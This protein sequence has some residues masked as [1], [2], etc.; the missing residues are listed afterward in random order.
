MQKYTIEEGW[1]RIQDD[2]FDLK[3][4]LS[5]LFEGFNQDERS[6]IAAS[7]CWGDILQEAIKRLCG[8]SDMWDSTDPTLTL[9]VLSKMEDRLISKCRW[10]LLRNLE[11]LSKNIASHQ[12]IYWKM[13]HD[14]NH[15]DFFQD[16]LRK[17]NIES[18]YTCDIKS[19]EEFMKMVE[20]KLD[21][22]KSHEEVKISLE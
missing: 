13:Y 7:L 14:P 15:G 4:N 12:H 8:E 20:E 19:H 10:S 1:L 3:L 6:Q 2:Q 22:M 9:E 21:A 11:D 5:Q 16:W 18:N 17:N